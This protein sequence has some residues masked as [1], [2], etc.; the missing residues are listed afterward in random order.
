MALYLIGDVQGCNA[1]LQRLLDEISFSPS[2]DTLFFLGDLV[3][4]GPDSAGVL[5]RLMSY[6]TAVQCVLGNHDLHLNAPD[7]AAMLDWL[8]WQ[9]MAI[10]RQHYDIDYL[11]VHAG[12]LPAWSATKTMAL[13]EE[14]EAVLRG[15]DL[16]EFLHQMYGNA[17]NG[18]NENSS[19]AFKATGGRSTGSPSMPPG[20]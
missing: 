20:R 14:V 9:P 10:L 1:A 13:A 12:V 3:N 15:P 17:P 8:R 16:P 5:R 7:R 4:R 11:M 6:G 2:R 19:P 18:W